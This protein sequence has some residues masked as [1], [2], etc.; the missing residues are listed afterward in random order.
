MR[1]FA[2]PIADRDSPV[3]AVPPVAPRV[4]D[5]IVYKGY[6]VEPGSYV[7]GHGVWSPRAV[8]SWKTAEGSWQ[9]TPLY[10]TSSAKFPTRDEADRRALDVARAWI[11]ATGERP[12]EP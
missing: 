1:R 3:G 7:V 2:P 4:D 11:D 6:R 12:P 10:A 9:R 5:D 8:V